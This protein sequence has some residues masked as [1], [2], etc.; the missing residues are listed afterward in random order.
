MSGWTYVYIKGY[1]MYIYTYVVCMY[2][3]C[4]YVGIYMLLYIK[5]CVFI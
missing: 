4:I 1:N 2:F 5:L 3:V